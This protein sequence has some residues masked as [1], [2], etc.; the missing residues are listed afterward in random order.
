MDVRWSASQPGQYIEIEWRDGVLYLENGPDE[1]PRRGHEGVGGTFTIEE[2]RRR[3]PELFEAYPGL[4][5]DL[6]ADLAPRLRVIDSTKAVLCTIGPE[7]RPHAVPCCF[8]IEGKKLYTPID[9]IKPKRTT[10]L[11]RLDNI[12]AH[13]AATVLIDEY[14]DDWDRLW[15]ARI[16]GS[17]Q[18]LDEPG[19]EPERATELLRAKYPQ[20]VDA[21][22]QIIRIEI[23]RW[24]SWPDDVSG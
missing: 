14:H 23:D 18:L 7:L 15:W 2:I 6:M 5:D 11:Q 24:V 1:W 22:L 16:D 4:H 8:V 9:R 21:D 19:W 12:A 13:P 20:Y 17:A 3:G 10:S